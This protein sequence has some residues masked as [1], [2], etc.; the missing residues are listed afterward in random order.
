MKLKDGFITHDSDGEQI[1]VAVGD[2][3]DKFHGLVRSNETAAFIIDCLKQESTEE[4][5]VDAVLWKFDAARHVVTKDVH[6]II[7]DLRKIGAIHE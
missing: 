3:A 6:N 7:T 4:Q 1:M 5:I 2:A